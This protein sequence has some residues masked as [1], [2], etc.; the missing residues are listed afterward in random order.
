MKRLI[1]C[2]FGMVYDT[3][4]LPHWTPPKKQ[5]NSI[6]TSGTRSHSSHYVPR[7]PRAASYVAGVKSRERIRPSRREPHLSTVSVLV[8]LFRWFCWGS[9]SFLRMF[10][11]WCFFAIN[12]ADFYMSLCLNGSFWILLREQWSRCTSGSRALYVFFLEV[13]PSPQTVQR[14]DFPNKVNIWGRIWI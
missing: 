11:N 12:L 7:Y 14:E 4:G 9:K 1:L 10:K 8:L 6:Q 5:R 3:L 13:V 2:D